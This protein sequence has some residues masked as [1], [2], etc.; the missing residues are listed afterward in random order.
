VRTEPETSAKSAKSDQSDESGQA[1]V[2][3]ALC[4]PLVLLLL[5]GLVQVGLVAREQIL[6]THAAREAVRQM[7]V[8]D[9]EGASVQQVAQRS[10]LDPKRLQIHIHRAGKS[11]DKVMAQLSYRSPVRVVLVGRLVGE[12]TLSSQAAMRHE[13]H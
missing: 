1:T 10:G 6:V 3:L 4:L 8:D 13:G 7:A 9:W 12:I 5:I 11:S 2:E